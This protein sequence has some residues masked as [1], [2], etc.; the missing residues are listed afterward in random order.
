MD[1]ITE[2]IETFDIAFSKDELNTKEKTWILIYDSF[3]NGYN[4]NL[5]GDGNKGFEG[6][7]GDLNPMSRSIVQLTIKGELVKYWDCMEYASQELNINKAHICGICNNTYGR[8]STGGY[9]FMYKEDYQKLTDMDIIYYNNEIGEYNKEPVV[10]L[11]LYGEFIQEFRS[12]SEASKLVNGTTTA[13]ISKCCKKERKSNGGFMWIYKRDYSDNKTYSW[14]GIHDGNAKGVVQLSLNGEFISEYSSI[15]EASKFVKNTSVS[16]I[17][18]C[19]NGNAKS[20]ANYIWVFKNEYSMHIDYKLNTNHT[21]KP[22][23]IVKLSLNGDFLNEYSSSKEAEE[24]NDISRKAITKC[25]SGKS[26]TS[27]GYIW[28]YKENYITIEI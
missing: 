23:G 12:M 13:K 14:E 21:G 17:S 5:G 8:K 28:K 1:L 27:G 4:N 22:K 9:M 7:K 3:N 11:S 10:Q 24:Y 20:H 19:C 6:L 18:K 16:K 15:T 25:C 2:V 26:K